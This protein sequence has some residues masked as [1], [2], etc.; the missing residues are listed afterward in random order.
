[1]EGSDGSSSLGAEVDDLR[2]GGGR[3]HQ[4]RHGATFM[5]ALGWHCRLGPRTKRVVGGGDHSGVRERARAGVT[6]EK[7]LSPHPLRMLLLPDTMAS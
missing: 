3:V 1:M 4:S 7:I 6:K 2:G 5:P